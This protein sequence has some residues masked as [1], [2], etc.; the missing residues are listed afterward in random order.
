[1]EATVNASATT[2]TTTTSHTIHY[3]APQ[4]QDYPSP[5]PF[6][7][8]S[9]DGTTVTPPI[10]PAPAFTYPAPGP[11]KECEL[12]DGCRGQSCD[13]Y[14]DINCA[15]L[16]KNFMCDCSGCQC[17]LDRHDLHVGPSPSPEDALKSYSC[18][19]DCVED[20]ATCDF[21]EFNTCAFLESSRGCDCSG[22]EC[23]GG[24]CESEH[25][26]DV[27]TPECEDWCG[28]TMEEWESCEWCRCKAC[29][30]C[31][32]GGGEE[33]GVEDYLDT[34]RVGAASS[35]SLAIVVGGMA[36]VAAVVQVR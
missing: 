20:G 26:G 22:C 34:H 18:T 6:P 24:T 17:Q 4:L 5:S 7:A 10:L 21:W 1:M 29:D 19:A 27:D 35:V 25:E 12:S 31:V 11:D 36:A 28:N 16:E 15:T 32:I 9:P 13:E 23:T 33:D 30:F 2:T 14:T 8:P 3:V